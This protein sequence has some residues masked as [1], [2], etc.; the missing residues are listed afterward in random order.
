MVSEVF[1]AF[2]NIA[3]VT[4][5][6]DMSGIVALLELIIVVESRLVFLIELQKRSLMIYCL[7]SSLNGSDTLVAQLFPTASS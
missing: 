3:V 5:A 4:R 2:L 1:L 6:L 7:R